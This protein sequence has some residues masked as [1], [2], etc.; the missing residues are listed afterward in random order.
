M[1]EL[2]LKPLCHFIL[3]RGV[4]Y[5]Q[6]LS[7]LGPADQEYLTKTLEFSDL[8]QFLSAYYQNKD[9]LAFQQDK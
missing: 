3:A 4:L 2:K 9:L 7:R 1:N 5:Q 8:F 6:F